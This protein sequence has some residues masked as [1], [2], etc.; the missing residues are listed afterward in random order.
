MKG[1]APLCSPVLL[2]VAVTFNPPPPP[3]STSLSATAHRAVTP[4]APERPVIW[5]CLAIPHPPCLPRATGNSWRASQGPASL[6]VELTG[7]PVFASTFPHYHW[8]MVIINTASPG[9][10][11][12]GSGSLG[13]LSTSHPACCAQWSWPGAR[14]VP[15]GRSARTSSYIRG[16]LSF[17]AR[18][19]TPQH[20]LHFIMNTCLA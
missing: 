14:G 10:V 8:I 18:K 19:E 5:F 15:A 16:P 3:R 17:S 1:S 9:G 2:G 4:S 11:A 20:R 13:S 12:T 7:A 6:R